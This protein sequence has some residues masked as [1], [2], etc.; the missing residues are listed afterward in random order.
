HVARRVE[1]RRAGPRDRLEMS[2][3]QGRLADAPLADPRRRERS[4]LVL[5]REEPAGRLAEMVADD[6][7]ADPADPDPEG[8]RD[9]G[10]VQ[11]LEE[12]VAVLP[13]TREVDQDRAGDAAE[14]GDTALPDLEP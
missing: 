4:T 7:V 1:Q 5:P 3:L 14:Q 8:E 11:H 13:H 2:V 12:P 6:E 10:F 9:R